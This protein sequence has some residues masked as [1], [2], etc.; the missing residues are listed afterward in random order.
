MGRYPPLSSSIRQQLGRIKPSIAGELHYYPCA[1]KL[2][3]GEVLPCVYL[4]CD[5]HYIKSWGVYPENDRA[6]NWIR[7][8]D[9]AGLVDSPCRLPARFATK[10]YKH[11]ESGMGYTIFTVVFS[12]LS[13]QAYATGNAVD[14]IRYPEGKRPKNVLWVL[15]HKGRDAEPLS[16]P[17][18][19]WCLYSEES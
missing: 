7:V 14:F 2:V 16:C 13:R 19:Y 6:K 9:V 3:S 10:L 12:D 5:E 1:T 17:A 11:G 18:Y 4:V 8:Q 15:P